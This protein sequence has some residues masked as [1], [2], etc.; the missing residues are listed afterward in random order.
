[1]SKSYFRSTRVAFDKDLFVIKF[2]I[3]ARYIFDC[4]KNT[5]RV[6]RY[7]LINEAELLQPFRPQ[8]IPTSGVQIRPRFK[9]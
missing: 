7:A 4:Q 5:C 3:L 2:D 6:F 8:N 9:K 1:M